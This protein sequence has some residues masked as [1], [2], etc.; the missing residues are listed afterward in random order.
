[1]TRSITSSHWQA[2]PIAKPSTAAIQGFSCR[3]SS[4]GSSNGPRSKPRYIFADLAELALE[5]ELE[6]G[7]LAVVEV[8]QVDARAENAPAGVFRVGGGSPAEDADP[9]LVVEQDEVD[10]DLERSGRGVVL[11]VQEGV[12]LDRDVTDV[13]LAIDADR[14][15]VDAARSPEVV[16]PAERRCGRLRHRVHEVEAGARV[17]EHV[18]DE[19]PLVD[20]EPLLVL[21]EELSLGLDR[22]AGRQLLGKAARPLHRRDP[23]CGVCRRSPSVRSS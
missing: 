8:R 7:D 1:M 14:A 12:I 5:Q 18:G 21:L 4:P 23:R 9:N 20:L 22:G 2:P 10:G 6:Q 15:E 11:G 17:G 19:D 13:A 16:E 3:L